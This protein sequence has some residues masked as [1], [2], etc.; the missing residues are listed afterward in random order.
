MTRMTQSPIGY[1]ERAAAAFGACRQLPHSGLTRWWAAIARH[2]EP[3]PG[4]RV[5]DGGAGT[6][7][8]ATALA[9]WLGVT[10]SLS[11]PRPRCAPGPPAPP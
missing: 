9:D 1:N 6:G 7:M 8:W 2:L 10:V 4:M 11:S 3:R 5:L